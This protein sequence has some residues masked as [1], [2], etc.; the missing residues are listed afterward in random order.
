MIFKILSTINFQPTFYLQNDI[1]EFVLNYKVVDLWVFLLWLQKLGPLEI[2]ARSYGRNTKTEQDVSISGFFQFWLEQNYFFQF[3]FPHIF[4]LFN[5][6]KSIL[7]LIMT[8]VFSWLH[9]YLISWM[10]LIFYKRKIHAM[11]IF[12]KYFKPTYLHVITHEIDVILPTEIEI[13]V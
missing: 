4:Y 13:I 6:P 10:V 11:S 2:C 1:F 8:L 7:Q 3:L 5:A 9:V 12:E